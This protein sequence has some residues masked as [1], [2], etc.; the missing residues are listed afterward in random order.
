MIDIPG[1]TSKQAAWAVGYSRGLA[2]GRNAAV[3]YLDKLSLIY[4]AKRNSCSVSD[5]RAYVYLIIYEVLDNCADAIMR[6]EHIEEKPDA[7]QEVKK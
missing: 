7:I 4:K 1:Y 2:D 5:P 3:S 6:N